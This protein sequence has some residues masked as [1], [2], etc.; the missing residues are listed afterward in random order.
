MLKFRASS[1]ADIMTDGKSE[2][3]S[4]GAKTTIIKLAKEFLYGYDERIDSKYL[5]KGI[6]CE[7]T[8]IE[9]L[10]SVLGT[11]YTKN[12]ERLTNDWITGE[13]DIVD[14]AKI[15]DIKTSWS[16]STFPVLPK[17]GEDKGYEWQL[18]AY[19]WLYDKPKASIAY[20]MVSTPQELIGYDDPQLHNV[21]H[22]TPDLRVTFVEYERNAAL[23]EKIKTK[24]A[25]ARVFYDQ[26]IHDIAMAHMFVGGNNA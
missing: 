7:D 4:V 18:R 13:A 24:V 5:K 14:A 2:E 11:T 3:L 20:C 19:M 8:S 1:L 12:T 10:N 9:L 15:I 25:A 21:D 6:Q 16:L 23:E 26:V 17:Q 22:I